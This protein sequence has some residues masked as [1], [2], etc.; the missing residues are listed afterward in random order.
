MSPNGR[1]SGLASGTRKRSSLSEDVGTIDYRQQQISIESSTPQIR[2]R[3][4]RL[5]VE[6]RRQSSTASDDTM[7]EPKIPA[8]PVDGSTSEPATPTLQY[9]S[10]DTYPPTSAA[11]PP[12]GNTSMQQNT[13]KKD[14][15]NKSSLLASS[16]KAGSKVVKA[17]VVRPARAVTRVFRG[18]SSKASSDDGNSMAIRSSSSGIGEEVE[19]IMA[20]GTE[21]NQVLLHS[22]ATTNGVAVY[23]AMIGT[24]V[25]NN[26]PLPHLGRA[27]S[28]SSIHSTRSFAPDTAVAAAAASKNADWPVHSMEA[29]T[30]Q[31]VLVCIAYMVGA[32][33]PEHLHYV[34]RT[35]EFA[36]TAW[37]TCVAILCLSFLQRRFPHV[38]LSE[39]DRYNLMMAAGAVPEE[40]EMIPSANILET[41]PLLRGDHRTEHRPSVL[42]KKTPDKTSTPAETRSIQLGEEYLVPLADESPCAEHPITQE[43]A[44]VTSQITE[45]QLLPRLEHPSLVPFYVIDAYS[46]ERVLCNSSKPH[47][48]STEWFEMDM[49]CLIRTPDAD[50]PKSISGT[51]DNDKVSNYMRSKARRF[52][53]QFR[54][55]LKKTPVGKQVYFA[56]ELDEPIKMG[57]VTRA[58]VGAAMAF[59]KKTN[60][61]FHY[62]ITGSKETPDGLWEK[63]HMSFTVEGS[64]DRLVV[65]KPDEKPPKLGQAIHESPESIK[66]RKKG[67][68]TDW[69]TEDT[70]TMA[71]WSSYVDFLEW[72]VLNLPGIRPFGL[73]S[74]LG[75][76]AI[77]LTMYL[78]DE[79][80]ECDKH[81]RKNITEIVK[82]ELS[83]D[84]MAASGPFATSWKQDFTQRPNSSVMPPPR[85]KARRERSTSED[86][87]ARSQELDGESSAVDEEFATEF[88]QFKVPQSTDDAMEEIEE[89]DEDVLTAAELGEGIYLRSGDSVVLRES[90]GEFDSASN[91]SV[92]NGGGFAV[93]QERDVAIVIEKAKRS[94]KN[95]LIRSGDTVIFKMIQNKAGSDDVETRY[96]TIHRGWWLKWVT[97]MPSKNG[98]FTIFT[99]EMELGDKSTPTNETQSSFL[100]LGG[101]FTLRHKRWSKYSVGIAAEPSTTYGGRML[102]L[103]NPISK[104]GVPVDEDKQNTGYHSDEEIDLEKEG[105][106]MAK[107]GWL[108]PL[109]LRAFDSSSVLEPSGPR[110]SPRSNSID[111]DEAPDLSFISPTTKLIFSCDHSKADVPAWIEMMDR[112]ERVRQLAYVVRV[113][114]RAPDGGSKFE[115]GDNGIEVSD[116]QADPNGSFMRL[117]TGRELAHVMSVGQRVNLVPCTSK[118]LTPNG[119]FDA[120]DKEMLQEAD[121]IHSP[122]RS[123]VKVSKSQ[124]DETDSPIRRMLRHTSYTGGMTNSAIVSKADM[125]KRRMTAD[126]AIRLSFDD[127]DIGEE[128]VIDSYHE[129]DNADEYIMEDGYMDDDSSLSDSAS[130]GDEEQEQERRGALKKGKKLL[131]KSA[132]LA[133]KTVFGTGKLTAKTAKGKYYFLFNSKCS[134]PVL[135]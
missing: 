64:L 126:H 45:E 19:T 75:T 108:K 67:V 79:K 59:M 71:L 129:D 26:L 2:V 112:V 57:M 16:R 85:S 56:C 69:N 106:S 31:L 48:I 61:T 94:N 34:L 87:A 66:R 88:E 86:S 84:V 46:G 111:A 114:R 101:S 17:T 125:M 41:T 109:V 58:F 95:K 12:T 51:P 102:G 68:L 107:A 116:A 132:K 60:P 120:D 135:Y 113:T 77:N 131:G 18:S 8:L 22:S 37:V 100:T 104:S 97:T 127:E 122:I 117:R 9:A 124:G 105:P 28:G 98:F 54:V 36:V 123:A 115:E 74:V 30:R 99:H 62:S 21:G 7:D 134:S 81:Y 82:L 118:A 50:D 24:G 32:N 6:T 25:A 29:L 40:H 76:Q 91:S 4:G 3:G 15:R 72:K 130:S 27:I 133:K 39:R 42:S 55:K 43:E 13:A 119:S 1:F 110:S 14:N 70:Y 63:P 53:F 35:T 23:G 80:R 11:T 65:T 78:I 103:Y 83:N 33:Y 128:L 38:V 5:T 20:R 73:S 96:L 121:D 10:A 49:L 47:H 44:S 93:L 92:T 52:E 90:R 89:V